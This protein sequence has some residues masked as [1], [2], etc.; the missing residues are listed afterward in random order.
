MILKNIS[1][2]AIGNIAQLS[3]TNS[4]Q[5]CSKSIVG[6]SENRKGS[7][8][9]QYIY[10]VGK[11]AQRCNQGAEFRSGLSNSQNAWCRGLPSFR[12]KYLVDYVNNTIGGLVVGS[13]H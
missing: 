13:S 10:Q 7:V 4:S 9:V 12:N 3:L 6:R 1:Q 11:S 8:A 2:D 5:E